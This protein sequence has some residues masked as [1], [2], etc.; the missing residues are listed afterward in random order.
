MGTG[1]FLKYKKQPVPE[2]E[3]SPKKLP[4]PFS[5]QKFARVTKLSTIV[6]HAF[7]QTALG[8]S[9]SPVGEQLVLIVSAH[10]NF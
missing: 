4:V 7:S 3:Q 5:G 8:K 6:V 9:G 10:D 2:K 1:S